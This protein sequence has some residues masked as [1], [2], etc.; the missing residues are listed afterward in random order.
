MTNQFQIYEQK[1]FGSGLAELN[2]PLFGFLDAAIEWNKKDK[3]T[4]DLEK[5]FNQLNINSLLFCQPKEPYKTI[6]NFLAA[7]SDG[8]IFPKDCETRTF[9]HDLPVSSTFDI[10][11]IISLL[12]KRKGVIIPDAGIITF[13]TVSIEQTFI[14]FSSI[15]FS[16]FVKFFSDYLLSMKN[17]TATD[18]Q[19]SVFNKVIKDLDPV[20]VFEKSLLKSPFSS[21]NEIYQALEQAGKYTVEYRLVD[22]FFGNI[23][24]CDGQTMYISQTGSSLD[25]LKGYVDP[26]SLNGSSCASITS[27]SEL[28]AHVGIFQETGCKAILH[29][30]PKFSVIMS[31][32]CEVDECKLNDKCHNKCPFERSVDEIPI[33]SGEVGTGKYGL[34]NTVPK[35]IKDNKGV[36]VYGHG[37]FTTGK[38]DFNEAFQ[39]LLN[40]EVQCR[41]K[42]FELIGKLTDG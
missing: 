39:S 13:G 17:G 30:H 40:I 35:A 24:Y 27:S 2:A 8:T 32:N 28:S 11:K 34:C 19:K 36:I 42:Y 14:T 1:L 33:V 22:S 38:D 3:Y 18:I 25:D 29:G 7:N 37:L 20:P 10:D 23:S 16:C 15:C 31:M 5:I 4:I 21:K 41:N 9:L 26:Y 6:I 12:K